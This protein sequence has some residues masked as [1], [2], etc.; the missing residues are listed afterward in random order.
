MTAAVTG[1]AMLRN[2]SNSSSIDSATTPA[3]S[4]GMRLAM[5]AVL[6]IA[7]AVAPPT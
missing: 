3:I 7:V 4:S 2:A 5:L 1:I 6:S